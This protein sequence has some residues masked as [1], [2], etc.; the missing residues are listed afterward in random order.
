M[1]LLHCQRCDTVDMSS[2][3]GPPNTTEAGPTRLRQIALVAKDLEKAKRQLTYVLGT[4]VIYEDPAVGQWGL[5]N[6]LVPLGGEIIEVVSPK[7]PGTTAGRLLERRGGDG[8]YMIIMQTTDARKRKEYIEEKK[9]AKVIFTH[10][11]DDGFSA[12]YHPKGIRGSLSI[13]IAAHR[14]DTNDRI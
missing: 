9:L 2:R 10:D 14:Q 3:P 8:G 4:E 5:E 7:Q 12:Q 1:Y 11:Y 6:F 13:R